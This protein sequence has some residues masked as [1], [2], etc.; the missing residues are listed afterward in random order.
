[1]NYGA[2]GIKIEGKLWI[3]VEIYVLKNTYID[4]MINNILKALFK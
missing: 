2:K 1:M 4:A 3:F